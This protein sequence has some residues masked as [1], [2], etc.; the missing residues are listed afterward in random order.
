MICRFVYF[1][2][3]SDKFDENVFIKNRGYNSFS[4]ATKNHKEKEDKT[5]FEVY[6]LNS[7]INEEE[8][9]Y[10]I[11]EKLN[12]KDLSYLGKKDLIEE[13]GDIVLYHG[14][15]K[16]SFN[17]NGQYIYLTNDINHA[18]FHAKEKASDLKD[19]PLILKTSFNNLYN[20]DFIADNDCDESGSHISFLDSFNKIGSFCAIGSIS[21]DLFEIVEFESSGNIISTVEL[22][23]QNKEDFID[24]DL[25]ERIDAIDF[26]ELVDF[27][28]EL[29]NLD[30][31]SFDEDLVEEYSALKLEEMP[32]IVVHQYSKEIYSIVDGAHRAN[33]LA[34][35]GMKTI[36]AYLGIRK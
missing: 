27:P 12:L 31:W 34:R 36:K 5:F 9:L 2:E 15:T 25:L 23:H 30:E 13:V 19:A 18:V 29:L 1:F 14:T 17:G 6:I 35:N 8:I 4:F 11:K 24:G 21:I 28:I 7:N 16:E 3:T 20:L 22:I 33:A 32:P 10:N 26:Y